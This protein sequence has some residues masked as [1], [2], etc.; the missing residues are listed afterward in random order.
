MPL[1][2]ANISRLLTSFFF[3]YQPQGNIHPIIKTEAKRLHVLWNIKAGFLEEEATFRELVENN[4]NGQMSI[5]KTI[6]T[7][8]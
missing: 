5:W 1:Y 8:V 4:R 6:L 3:N 7:S 2:Q